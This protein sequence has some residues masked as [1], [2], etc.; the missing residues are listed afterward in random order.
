MRVL[1]AGGNVAEALRV[2]EELRVR[3]RD[4][5]GIAPGGAI[6]EVHRSLLARV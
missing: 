4:E 2:Y 5:L 6:Q 3:L 1:A